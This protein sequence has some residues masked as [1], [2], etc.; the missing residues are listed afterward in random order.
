[1]TKVAKRNR[2]S[3]EEGTPP[4]RIA[5]SEAEL[6]TIV[7]DLVREVHP[8][9]SLTVQPE[10]RL[11]RDLGLD[12]LSRAELLNRVELAFQ[13][14]L[15][16]RTLSES[17]TVSD[18]IAALDRAGNI[19]EH[20]AKRAASAEQLPDIAAPHHAS[21]LVAVLD[22]YAANHG[23]RPHVTFLPDGAEPETLTYGAL[24]AS[25]RTIASALIGRGVKDGDRI[26]IMLPTGL[27]FFE[28]F[29]GA[30]Y[31]GAVPVPI[32]PP[33]RLTQLEEYLKRQAGILRNCGARLLITTERGKKLG[34]SIVWQVGT[35]RSVVSV[36]DLRSAT[37]AALPVIA[38]Q[39]TAMLQYT[40]G[41]TGDPKGVVLSHANLL[42]NIRSMGEAMKADARDI[43]VSWLPLYHDMGLIGAWLGSLY[44]GARLYVMSPLTFLAH[45]ESW[46]WAIHKYRATLSAAPNFAFE[47]CSNKITDAALD[48]LDLS[49]LRLVA[50]GAEPV[51]ASSIKRF[52]DRYKAYGFRTA[53]MAPSF[54]LAENAVGLTMPPLGRGPLI[55]Y[56]D[57]T[58]LSKERR[59]QPADRL[60]NNPLALVG[61]GHVLPRNEIR[62]VNDK[63]QAIPERS[64]GRLQFRGPS[65]TS[66]YF[67]NEQKTR[68]LFN[69]GWLDTGDLAYV[70][71]GELY[72]AGR[73]KDM[74]I[75]AG[76]HYFPQLLEAPV[77]DLPS[78]IKSGVA[79]FGVTDLK[80]GTERIVIAVETTALDS[81]S[82]GALRHNI[83]ELSATVLGEPVDEVVLLPPDTIPRTSNGK[84]RRS[85][86]RSLFERGM[87]GKNEPAMSGARWHLLR[88][89]L[90]A[91]ARTALR[92]VLTAAY[93]GWWWAIVSL[94]ATGCWLSAMVLP[95]LSWRWGAV[96]LCCR[97]GLI[98]MGI[99]YRIDGA[100]MPRSHAVLVFNH[101]SYVDALVLAPLIPGEPVYAAKKEFADQ[102]FVGPFLRRLGVVFVERRDLA[103]SIADAQVMRA[104][105]ESGRLLVAFPEG[106][107]TGRAG[108]GPFHLGAF[109]VASELNIP[110]IPGAIVGT[111]DMLRGDQWWPKWSTVTVVIDKPVEPSGRGFSDTVILRDKV[112][113]AILAHIREPDLEAALGPENAENL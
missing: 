97:G 72:I 10:S 76:R 108:L 35:L 44:F 73:I 109:K 19:T 52:C 69:N 78:V 62:I 42:A 94:V 58:V 65:A 111:R 13:V 113:A 102:A 46:L 11:D 80:S 95:K 79:L 86:A 24:A 32:Y 33:A 93:A 25:S 21:N 67:Q 112:R 3:A 70:A 107:F 74:V 14:R 89:G 8:H 12:S 100:S 37:L 4:S 28:A 34:S 15:P 61:C 87:L 27:E 104:V 57:R 60:D 105:T 17:E 5:Q 22:W 41:S 53:A 23:E 56:V 91:R 92:F 29:F 51:S 30:L 99:P 88:D 20:R 96:R 83:F 26:A 9:R 49:S 48:G 85:E 6:I 36:P 39:T 82:V 45:P 81:E 40:S 18:Y 84:I 55:D 7:R 31:A 2:S 59:A 75:R 98:L 16:E 77:S 110:V 66:G 47:I 71:D 38:P 1:M 90:I 63:G 101:S 68:E 54:G 43:F 103:T 50:N 106:T 64:V